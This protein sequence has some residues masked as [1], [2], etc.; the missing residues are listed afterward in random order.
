MEKQQENLTEPKQDRLGKWKYFPTALLFALAIS[1]YASIG[2]RMGNTDNPAGVQLAF[3][4]I[5]LTTIF[6]ALSL[7]HYDPRHMY[8]NLC[9]KCC[10]GKGRKAKQDKR[11]AAPTATEP[12]E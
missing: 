10:R 2:A 11:D 6:L 1:L 8:S 3:W 12:R 5:F 9:Q 7:A 4:A